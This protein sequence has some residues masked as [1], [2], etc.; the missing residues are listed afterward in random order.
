MAIAEALLTAEDFY[1]LPDKGRHTELVRGRIATMNMPTPRHGQ[2]CSKTNRIVGAFLDQNLIG[3]LV[4]NDSGMI[5]ER[6]PD[7]VRGM[8]VAFYSFQTIPPGP[9]PEGYLQEAPDLVFE[10]R[11]AGDRWKKILGKVAEYLNAGVQAVCVLDQQIETAH[12]YYADLPVRI[13][14]VE[15]DLVIPEVLG[16]FPAKVKRFFE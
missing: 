13:F 2:I 11:S 4:T 8:E 7:T 3:H 16:E 5:T 1:L 15:E 10:V 9:L 12:V 14:Q 6:N